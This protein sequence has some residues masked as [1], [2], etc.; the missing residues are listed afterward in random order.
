MIWVE[1]SVEADEEA[2][3]GVAEQFRAFG[4]GVAIDVPFLQP[5]LEDDPVQ[6]TTRKAVVKTYLR[7]DPTFEASCQ[8]IERGLWHLSQ[9]RQVGAL[10]VVRIAEEDWANSWRPFFPVVHVGYRIV[11][12]PAWRRYHRR[13]T[14]VT[15]RLDP[16][17]AFGTGTH[18]TTRLCLEL[19]EPRVSPD[20]NVLD[21]GTGSGILA[22][23]AVK[24][25]ARHVVAVDV[26]PVAV[27]AAKANVKLNHLSWRIDVSEGSLEAVQK[28]WP[29][30]CF[31][32]IVGNLTARVNSL[33]AG[34]MTQLLAPAG[35]VI[36]SGILEEHAASVI[37]AFGQQGLRLGERRQEG[38]WV[39]LT[40]QR[41]SA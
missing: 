3:E 5:H 4:Q 16:G 17:L 10:R 19:M 18:P 13:D 29:A 31:P 2:I 40:F 28:R 12:V 38:E 21:V 7:D 36:A 25:G 11:I 41:A 37:E 35:S 1:L 26:D 33:L 30:E 22:I 24:L 20:A 6:D 34:S 8:Q 15:V 14:E 23:A 32:L 39:A 27:S 9:L